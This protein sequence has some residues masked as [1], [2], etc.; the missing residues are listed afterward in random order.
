MGGTGGEDDVVIR[1]RQP[2]DDDA[3][4]LL[5]DDAF[6]GTYESKLVEDLR[7]GKLAVIELV[8]ADG[9][10]IVGHILFSVLGVRRGNRP[11]RAL[12]LAPVSVRRDRQRQGIGS[13][14]IRSGLERARQLGWQAVFLVGH[15]SYYPRFGF[16]SERARPF[17][18]PFSG[19][20]Y[21]ALELVPDALAGCGFVTYPPAFGL[22]PG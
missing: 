17:A 8:A 2:A 9:P 7:A 5:N 13:R 16:S 4:R 21:M 12:A 1:E 22:E 15:P 20:A 11:L 6:G 18:A 3:I 10:A 19:A 14:L